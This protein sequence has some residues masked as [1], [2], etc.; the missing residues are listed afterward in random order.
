MAVVFTML[1]SYDISRTLTPIIIRLLL[2]GEHGYQG[3]KRWLARFHDRFNERFDRFRDFYAWLLSGILRR[4][5]FTPLV[6]GSVVA[7]AVVVA[8]FV[9]SDFFPTID[10]G[11]IELHVRTHPHRGH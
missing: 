1:A 7:G 11:L 5:V 2:R 10:A 3:P 6:A 4:R 8:M 9:G